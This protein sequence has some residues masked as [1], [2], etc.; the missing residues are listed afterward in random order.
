[1][2][3]DQPTGKELNEYMYHELDESVDAS[4]VENPDQAEN[5][6]RSDETDMRNELTLSEE[7]VEAGTGRGAFNRGEAA[8]DGHTRP[9]VRPNYRPRAIP[10]NPKI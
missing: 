7:E 4:Q 9:D 8:A 6:T 3:K 1:M 5:R 2:S 10:G